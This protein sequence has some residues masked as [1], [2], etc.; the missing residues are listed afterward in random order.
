[1]YNPTPSSPT[2][3]LL[4]PTKTLCNKTVDLPIPDGDEL[5]RFPTLSEALEEIKAIGKISG[6]TAI[7]SLLLYSRAMISMLFL[8]ILVNSNSLVALLLLVL[9]TLLATL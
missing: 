8:A 1:M 7:T 5:H 3:S 4:P 2:P 6:P 9:Q